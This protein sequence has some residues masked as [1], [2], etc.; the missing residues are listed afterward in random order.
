MTMPEAAESHVAPSEWRQ[1]W[2][3]V[4]A[5]SSGMALAATISYS[6]AL[7]IAPLEKEFGWSRANI[8]SGHVI[9]GLF[10]IFCSPWTGWLVDRFGCRR[11][12]L[13]AAV[14]MC[15]SLAMLSLAG[16]SLWSWYALWLVVAVAVVLIQPM[17]WTSGV[18]SLFHERR[19]LALA[20]TLCG[21]SFCS[22]V[23][24]PLTYWLITHLGW[25][26]AFVGLAA[27]WGAVTLPILLLFLT[28]ATDKARRARRAPVPRLPHAGR[29]VRQIMLT[30]RFLTLLIAGFCFGMVV[31]PAVVTIVPLLSANGIAA[32]K[33]A[34]I[35]ASV[36][37]A[38]IFG[39]LNI[40]L[41]LDRLP[42]RFIAAACAT[43]P[44]I[45]YAIL[46]ARP[47]S[48]PAATVA[49]LVLGLALG[50]ELDIL[51][52]LVSRYFPIRNFGTL[53]GTIGGFITLASSVGPVAL[54]KVYDLTHSYQPALWGLIPLCLLAAL[55]MLTLGDYPPREEVIG[56]VPAP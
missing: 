23:T 43:L 45:A 33:A 41:M 7:F 26:L 25:R 13:I 31:V 50:A 2:P 18:T 39:R 53:F 52:Y 5:A 51:A 10:T 42:G 55:L 54:N 21:S 46:I 36:G 12:G 48:V 16:P 14:A 49:T 11:V 9:A 19:G 29:E 34:G 37:F 15:I 28:S 17:V 44:I 24:P 3:A 4:L 40:G 1:H 6:T 32:S 8:S 20:F 22:V 38:S 47:G 30:R 27:I 35:A 56:D